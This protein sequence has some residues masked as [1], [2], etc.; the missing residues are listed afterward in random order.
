MS[1]NE[2][3]RTVKIKIFQQRFSSDEFFLTF[4]FKKIER[5][6]SIKFSLRMHVILRGSFQNIAMLKQTL[7]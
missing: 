4:G 2:R 3:L 7:E 5:N 6:K 1:L